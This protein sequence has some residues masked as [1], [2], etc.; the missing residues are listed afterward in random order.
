M[1]YFLKA[2][3]VKITLLTVLFTQ[4]L[5]HIRSCIW[6]EDASAFLHHKHW[7]SKVQETSLFIILQPPKEPSR[8]RAHSR[9]DRLLMDPNL[10]EA[11]DSN[12]KSPYS[13]PRKGPPSEPPGPPPPWPKNTGCHTWTQHKK[14]ATQGKKYA[15]DT[16]TWESHSETA[17]GDHA[18]VTP[19]DLPLLQRMHATK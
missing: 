8:T 16:H 6:S 11:A 15:I 3:L 18:I 1:P 17:G 9:A 19:Q 12:T 10:S 14:T 4:R 5:S 13:K 7:D 2:F